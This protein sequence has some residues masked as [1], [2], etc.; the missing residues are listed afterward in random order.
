MHQLADLVAADGREA[1]RQVAG[2]HAPGHAHHLG[3]RRADR[4]AQHPVQ[5]ARQQQAQ[6]QP[7][8]QEAVARRDQVCLQLIHIGGA[9]NHQLPVRILCEHGEALARRAAVG[10][11]Q[12]VAQDAVLALDHF[13][14]PGQAVGV[15]GVQQV[16]AFAAL[17]AVDQH[18]A[19]VGARLAVNDEIAAGLA[20]AVR[21][22]LVLEQRQFGAHVHAHV[23]RADHLAGG[24]AHR[25]VLAHVGHAEQ[26]R[27]PAERLARHQRLVARV[28][29]VEQRADGPF[30]AL[31]LERGGHAHE[32]VAGAGEHGGDGAAGAGKELVGDGE[33]EV[34]HRVAALEGRRGLAG[35]LHG[36]RRVHAVR[37]GHRVREGGQEAIGLGAHGAVEQGDHV[38]HGGFLV[39]HGRLRM[40]FQRAQAGLRDRQ[41]KG[42]EYQDQGGQAGDGQPGAQAGG[43]LGVLLRDGRSHGAVS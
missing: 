30:A 25:L 8:Q 35:H 29:T 41:R 39:A 22:D 5:A 16:L 11:G 2:G 17:V 43:R 27:Q 23:Q 9:G 34:H 15:L 18:L 20:D 32:I 31:F 19:L 40:A 37:T 3:Q 21:A 7:Q 36:L 24:V 28:G 4:T 13:A 38:A 1:V 14:H 26:P 33:V 12:R 6:R 42:A 10:V